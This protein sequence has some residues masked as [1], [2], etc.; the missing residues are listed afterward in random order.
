MKKV[1]EL[2]ETNGIMK[3]SC[4]CEECEPI[5]VDFH[6]PHVFKAIADILDGEY[7]R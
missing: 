1:R 6:T 3:E 7:F 4:S 2:C 5:V